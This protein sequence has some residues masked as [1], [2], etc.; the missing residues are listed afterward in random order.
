MEGAFPGGTGTLPLLTSPIFN[1]R[2]EKFRDRD[3]LGAVRGNS[4]AS[5]PLGRGHL[6]WTSGRLGGQPHGVQV[7]QCG[8]SADGRDGGRHRPEKAGRSSDRHFSR[9][10]LSL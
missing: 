6:C 7:S 9:G 3:M 8:W 10:I 1:H 5:V 2:G 4:G